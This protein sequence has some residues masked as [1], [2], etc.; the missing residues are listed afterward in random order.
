[1]NNTRLRGTGA[2][3]F[4]RTNKL[5]IAFTLTVAFLCI[6]PALW[7]QRDVHTPLIKPSA[8]A[9]APAF[10]LTGESGADVKLS[11]YHGQVILLNFWATDCG[12]CVLEIPRLIDV[13]RNLR[14]TDFTVIGVDMDMPYGG[15]KSAE[16]AWKRVRPFT[17]SHGMN[18]PVL[19]GD[20]A[21]EK[22]YGINAYPASFIIDK[23]G[24]IAAK[25]VGIVDTAN[26]EENVRTLLQN[27]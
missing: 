12:G 18:Y 24:R 19:M 3:V 17:A 16:E 13:Q 20:S 7:A 5:E 26:V 2:V 8:R 11:H 25:Y 9:K 22:L 1:M 23:T 21:T 27:K 10:Q 14:N 4:R 15:V 6:T